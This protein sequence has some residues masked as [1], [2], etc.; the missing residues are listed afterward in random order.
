MDSYFRI[1]IETEFS[2]TGVEGMIDVPYDI[3]NGLDMT[4]YSLAA[5]Q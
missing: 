1:K 4:L 2:N 3:R 5:G